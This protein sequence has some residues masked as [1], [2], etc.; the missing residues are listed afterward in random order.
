MILDSDWLHGYDAPLS[1][2]A[3][4]FGVNLFRV[5][6][7]CSTCLYPEEDPKYILAEEEKYRTISGQPRC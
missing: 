4:V 2:C 1:H 3:T 6:H 5:R 7:V